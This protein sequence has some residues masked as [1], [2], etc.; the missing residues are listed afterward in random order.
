MNDKVIVTRDV[1]AE[2]YGTK[3]LVGEEYTKVAFLKSGTTV[4]LVGKKGTRSNNVNKDCW[5]VEGNPEN[6]RFKVSGT[7]K[8]AQ[9]KVMATIDGIV[10]AGNELLSE[11]EIA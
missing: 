9:V 5:L 7:G 10:Y 2:K 1:V 4:T 11:E 3:S 6:S 8:Q